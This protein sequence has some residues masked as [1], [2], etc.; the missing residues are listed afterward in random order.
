[1]CRSQPRDCDLIGLECGLSIRS[2][3][4]SKV[5]PLCSQDWE[6]LIYNKKS[7]Q[8]CDHIF[9]LLFKDNQ[10]I[11]KFGYQF[12]HS[13]RFNGSFV[14]SGK[15]IQPSSPFQP[16]FPQK[17][18]CFMVQCF[19]T[20]NIFHSNCN[21]GINYNWYTL[22]VIIRFPISWHLRCNQELCVPLDGL[23]G[24]ILINVLSTPIR[25]T[26]LVLETR[27]MNWYIGNGLHIR[28]TWLTK[29][30]NVLV[31]K[32]IHVRESTYLLWEEALLNGLCSL[33]KQK[34]SPSLS[35]NHHSSR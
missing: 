26:W 29:A 17:R 25:N 5:V 7:S 2:F 8:S 10:A 18:H 16:H 4:T 14:C 19:P 13:R 6:A 12:L 34:S 33:A 28:G 15:Q 27:W 11:H 21:N 23:K 31:I 9:L 22:T 32:S 35:R 20:P 30:R 24:E 3:Q 1:M